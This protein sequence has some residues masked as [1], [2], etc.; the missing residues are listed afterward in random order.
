MC[1]QCLSKKKCQET[2]QK[3]TWFNGTCFVHTGGFEHCTSES[4]SES[5]Q[6]WDAGLRQTFLVQS[7]YMF[8]FSSSAPPPTDS[9]FF[10]LPG[11]HCTQPHCL[12]LQM[13]SSQGAGF[14][15]SAEQEL[16]QRLGNPKRF[17]HFFF[18]RVQLHVCFY[19]DKN[20]S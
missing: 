10:P 2:N 4:M 11:F 8:G 7:N 20:S 14:V 19:T 9:H 6:G 16:M 18:A 1:I 13:V 17:M 5:F 12:S 15:I 3:Q